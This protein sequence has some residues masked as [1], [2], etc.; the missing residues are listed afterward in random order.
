MP[1]A[2]AATGNST[3]FSNPETVSSGQHQDSNRYYSSTTS[4][5]QDERL[6]VF[7]LNYYH[8]QVPFEITLWIVLA[9]LAKVGKLGM[10]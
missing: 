3:T 8:V 2:A 6:S 1:A 10:I 5:S 4:T 9:S 7:S